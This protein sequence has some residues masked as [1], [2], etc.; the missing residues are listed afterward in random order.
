[1][2]SCFNIFSLLHSVI[3]GSHENKVAQRCKQGGPWAEAP[4]PPK[5]WEGDRGPPN[6]HYTTAKTEK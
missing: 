3:N 5:M 4:S 2:E 6:S 1:M